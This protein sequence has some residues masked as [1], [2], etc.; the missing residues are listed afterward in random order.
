MTAPVQRTGNFDASLKMFASLAP[1]LQLLQN[2]S[3]QYKTKIRE[4][5]QI[6]E[7]T[8]RARR[9]DVEELARITG[10]IKSAEAQYSQSLKMRDNILLMG[11]NIVRDTYND[12][13][14]ADSLVDA[15]C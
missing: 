4:L 13:A 14:K 7:N 5:E 8:G 2:E 11:Y 1:S 6:L 3:A 9:A 10:E 15:S 12:S